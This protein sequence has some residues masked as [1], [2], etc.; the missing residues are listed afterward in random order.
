MTRL[1][2]PEFAT[3]ILV[4]VISTKACNYLQ[5]ILEKLH[6]LIKSCNHKRNIN[7]IYNCLFHYNCL[8]QPQ[9]LRLNT[10]D[11]SKLGNL[12]ER[13]WKAQNRVWYPVFSIKM[14]FYS[15]IVENSQ[16]ATLNFYLKP[17]FSVKPNK[18]QMYFAKDCLWK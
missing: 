12:N 13:K 16:K 15:Y 2:F 11:L 17:R 9:N 7:R 3:L 1:H 10:Q 4:Q 5:K 8:Q 18:F 6:K 14:K